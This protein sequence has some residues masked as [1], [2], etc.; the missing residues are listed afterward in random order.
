VL[1]R[2]GVGLAAGVLA[3]VLGLAAS[4]HAACNGPAA[5]VGRLK[6]HPTTDNAVVLGSWYAGH[7][8]F[9]CAVETFRSALTHDPKSAQLHYLHGLALLALRRTPDAES[10]I[11]QSAR[12]EPGVIKPHLLL[13]SIYQDQGKQ[14]AAEE[15]WRLALGIDPASEPALEG[16]S[17]ALLQ[18]QDYPNTI[19]LLRD[20]PRTERLAINLSRAF[21]QLA[22][23]NDAERVLNEALKL[24]PESIELTKAM[25]VVLVRMHRNADA[26]K[27]V[28]DTANAHPQNIDEQVELFRVLVLLSQF[29]K[30]RPMVPKLL[31][32]RPHDSEVL[33]LSGIMEN[34]DGNPEQARIHLE[35]AVKLDPG[36]N[37]AHYHLGVV[38]VQ[39]HQWKEAVENLQKSI[40]LQIPLP[41]AHFELAKA[42]RGIGQADKAAEEMKA[43]QQLKKANDASRAAEAAVALADKNLDS[44]KTDEAIAKYREAL[45]SDPNDALYRYKL[46][47]A[48][49]KSGDTDGERTQL[50]Q[51]IKL[52][53]KLAA[54]QNELGFLLARAGDANGA[55]EHFQ[56][57][58]QSAPAWTEAWVNLAAE[59][60]VLAR[61]SEAREAISRAL[62]LDPANADARAL[63]DQL[64]RDPAA[65]QQPTGSLPPS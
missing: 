22:Y 2:P 8:Q 33:Y 23:L 4:A 26:I 32:A 12:L 9:E 17:A 44:G 5:L 29:E 35:E 59:L 43:Y 16:L 10:E 6:A 3:G 28:T 31:A 34:E 48:L 36:N 50:D 1:I 54:A 18:R 49:R 47:V 40:E 7:K 14:Q 53:P 39:L 27:L 42:L 30:A 64:A 11:E 61:F 19:M 41:E 55:V 60:A 20:A 38:E 24:H 51:A 46:S 13:A 21:G 63:S 56:L 15:Q 62:S 52:D 57:A 25:T 37:N 58:V 65:Q 45:E